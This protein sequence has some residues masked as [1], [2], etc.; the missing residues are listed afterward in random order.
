MP[1]P[2]SLPNQVVGL[3]KG[4]FGKVIINS[5]FFQ[6][7]KASCYNMGQGYAS[8]ISYLCYGQSNH[9][10]RPFSFLTKY[11][12]FPAVCFDNIKTQA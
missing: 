9:K 2:K 7:T 10:L 5:V 4:C 6:R 12:N 1:H 8:A 11:F 3:I